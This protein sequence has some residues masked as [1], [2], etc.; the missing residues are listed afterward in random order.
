M[1][2]DVIETIQNR[3]QQIPEV[4][5][6]FRASDIDSTL[7]VIILA[8]REFSVQT[9]M[10]RS[11]VGGDFIVS[12]MVYAETYQDLLAL[13]ESVETTIDLDMDI[14]SIARLRYRGFRLT[15]VENPT[16]PIEP[17]EMTYVVELCRT[18]ARG[19]N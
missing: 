19:R 6:V 7:P 8:P 9:D 15:P 11:D 18:L 3:L 14:P 13:I 4:S 12:V 5:V 2:R 1:Y 17:A 16:T 10:G